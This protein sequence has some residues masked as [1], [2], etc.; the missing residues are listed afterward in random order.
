MSTYSSV[1]TSVIGYGFYTL[2][3]ALL[4]LEEE[5]VDT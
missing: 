3:N 1:S 2:L 4:S 5:T